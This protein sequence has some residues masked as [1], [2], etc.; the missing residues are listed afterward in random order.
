MKEKRID[1]YIYIYINWEQRKMKKEEFSDK[2]EDLFQEEYRDLEP[3]ES[4]YLNNEYGTFTENGLKAGLKNR[5]VNMIAL[6]GIIGPGCLIGMG[7][8]LKVGGP[9]GL[10]VGFAIVSI[11]I[12]AMMAS[13]GEINAVYDA[14]FSILGSRFISKG[15]GASLAL[16]YILIWITVLIGEYTN[17][18]QSMMAYTDAIP[19][20]GWVLIFWGF[21]SVFS[22]F[23]VDWYGESEYYLGAFKLIYL[24][25]YYIFAVIYAAG[26][27][28]GHKPPN[29]FM[30]LPLNGGFKGIA[31]S[32]VYA[33]TFCS[34]VES[35]S[36]IAAET[37]NPKKAIPTAVKNTVGRMLIVYFGLAI[38]YGITVPYNDPLLT[39]SGRVLRSPMTIALTEAGWPNGKYFIA[40]IILITCISAINSSIYLASRTLYMWS[41][42]GYGPKI[43]TKTT[44]KGVPFI[45]IHTVH[46]FCLI[47]IMTYK[48]SASN[49]Y[50]YIVNISGVCAFIVWTAIS[51]IQYR[52]R[53]GWYLKGYTDKDLPFCVPFFPWT[54]LVALV[55]GTLL[56]LVQG[57]SY[58][59]PFQVGNFI[60][61]Y[62]CLPLF[63]IVWFAYDLYFKSWIV[64]LEDVDYEYGRR[65]DLDEFKDEKIQRNGDLEESFLNYEENKAI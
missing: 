57:W 65:P 49:A 47:S 22:S 1:I 35:V 48:G 36:V 54:N 52:F 25:A 33:G 45:A 43:F 30:T 15:F 38:A 10:I 27:I 59:K 63:F 8:M 23:G 58:L 21:F 37:R 18:S 11:L 40:T 26:G 24:V 39:D 64:K 32:F 60:D 12:L 7:N 29:L 41:L 61:A 28:K 44:K 56:T 34:G 46:L 2:N 55:L 13:I 9:V 19:S 14:N 50:N 42:N 6:C 4:N 51:V 31:N 17:L 62:I 53:K 20:Y 5:M 16:F 3:V